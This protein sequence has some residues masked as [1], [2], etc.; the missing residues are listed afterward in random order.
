MTEG[1]A[2]DLL[3]EQRQNMFPLEKSVRR[4]GSG[5]PPGIGQRVERIRII[6]RLASESGQRRHPQAANPGAA[7]R[8]ENR[9]VQDALEQRREFF[10][11][12]PAVAGGEF[13]HR[14]LN[15]IERGVVILQRPQG[16]PECASFDAFKKRGKFGL[17]RQL[18]ILENP[19]R[20]NRPASSRAAPPP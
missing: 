7:V 3:F 2:G 17:G 8:I 5:F 9:V 1:K 15:H 13:Q 4:I 11:R 12:T 18:S 6:L 14:V 10:S 16:L 20:E 19:F